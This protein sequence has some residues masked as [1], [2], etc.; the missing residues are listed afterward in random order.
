[1]N[2][3]SFMRNA[4]FAILATAAGLIPFGRKNDVEL[5]SLT[6]AHAMDN[7]PQPCKSGSKGLT[8]CKEH[9]G[10]CK[11][12][13]HACIGHGAGSGGGSGCKVEV[14]CKDHGNKNE[15]GTFK[16]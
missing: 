9:L 15:T 2:R 10:E 12:S 13:Y 7:D 14:H 3:R 1:M 4:G 8:S 16:K 6:D 11:G 5:L